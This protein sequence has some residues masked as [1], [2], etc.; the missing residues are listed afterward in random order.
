MEMLESRLAEY[1]APHA[2]PV[3]ALIVDLEAGGLAIEMLARVRAE[4][5][6][7]MAF[8][9]HVD[10]GGLAAAREVGAGQ[11][12]TRGAFAARLPEVLRKLAGE[13]DERQD[14]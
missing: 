11:V 14:G 7:T 3:K 5:L 2:D 1:A 4:T 10:V 8:G 12:M 6:A 13:A 9:P